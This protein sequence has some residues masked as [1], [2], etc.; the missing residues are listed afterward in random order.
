[1]LECILLGII[2]VD[3]V[4][5]GKTDG[6]LLFIVDLPS[7]IGIG[8]YLGFGYFPMG[9]VIPAVVQHQVCLS[10]KLQWHRL[11][12]RFGTEMY[13]SRG[14]FLIAGCHRIGLVVKVAQSE[15]SGNIQV[16]LFELMQIIDACAG[17]VIMGVPFES[18]FVRHFQLSAHSGHALTDVQ[19]VVDGKGH[20][21]TDI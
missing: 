19:Q 15:V 5:H 12:G 9:K 2:T 14:E 13:I 20:R 16:Y 4:I 17:T 10:V 6:N 18:F 7:H 11:I 21:L 3:Q 8:T 1:M